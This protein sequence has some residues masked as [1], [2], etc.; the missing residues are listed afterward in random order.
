MHLIVP[1]PPPGYIYEGESF[2]VFSGTGLGLIPLW[3]VYCGGC[4]DY[5]ITTDQLD[6][7][8]TYSSPQLLGYCSAVA[9]TGAT[10]PLY[11]LYLGGQFSD[12]FATVD[13][14]EVTT[15]GY[16]NQGILCYVP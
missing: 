6:S 16:S 2:Q 9:Q 10:R 12:H 5:K 3:Q 7:Y 1:N 15:S 8:P 13:F 4:T 11:R 14:N